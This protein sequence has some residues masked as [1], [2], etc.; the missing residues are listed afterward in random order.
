MLV[1]N[2]SFTSSL[3]RSCSYTYVPKGTDVVRRKDLDFNS[4]LQCKQGFEVPEGTKIFHYE[5]VNGI[6]E[7]DEPPSD[8]ILV[9]A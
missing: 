3:Q 6:P 4:S 1:Y 5:E 8:F 2:E 7:S 9:A